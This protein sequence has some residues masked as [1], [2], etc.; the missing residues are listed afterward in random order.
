[1]LDRNGNIGRQ[2]RSDK[3]G[4]WRPALLTVSC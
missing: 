3:H 4:Q 2:R 1:M